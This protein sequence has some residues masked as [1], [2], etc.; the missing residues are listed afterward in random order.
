[1]LVGYSL[2]KDSKLIAPEARYGIA[3]SQGLPR[4]LR[5]LLQQQIAGS[6]A[7]RVVHVLEVV[8]V[9]EQDREALSVP[10]CITHRLPCARREQSAIRQASQHIVVGQVAQLLL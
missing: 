1:M 4:P 7:E 3:L 10:L 6:M 2:Q 9:D 5:N 8:E